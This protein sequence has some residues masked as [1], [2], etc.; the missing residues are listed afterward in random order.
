MPHLV[1]ID[2]AEA[3][4]TEVA[5]QKRFRQNLLEGLMET[6]FVGLSGHGISSELVDEAHS[7]FSEFFEQPAAEK[8]RVGG[9][10]G[11]QRGFTPLGI[12]TAR[13]AITP[14]LKEFF[15]VGPEHTSES[16]PHS[17]YPDN[18]WPNRPAGLKSVS[19]QLYRAL[20]NVATKLLEE[21]ALA[22]ALPRATLS[23]MIFEGNSILRAVHYPPVPETAHPL[24]MRA[25]PHEDINLI[26]LLCAASGEGLEICLRDGEWVAAESPPGSLVADVGD[27]LARITNGRLPATTHRVVARGESA[28]RSRYAL[29]FFAHPRPECDLSVLPAFVQPGDQPRFPPTTAAR[30]LEERLREIGLISE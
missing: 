14:D 21:I 15:H 17:P 7:L 18:V 11:G 29:P 16:F 8:A 22:F 28:R 3:G 10:S 1:E 2:L 27:M 20:E 12:E 19:L 6:G 26:T 4:H 25:A 5:R 9:V 13:Q 30:F 23:E 24:A